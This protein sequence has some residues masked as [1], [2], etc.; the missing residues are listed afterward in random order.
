MPVL[1]SIAATP[2]HLRT[3]S[4]EPVSIQHALH[5][6]AD[7][8]SAELATLWGSLLDDVEDEIDVSTVTQAVDDDDTLAVLA[9]FA[10]AWQTAVERPAR[11]LLPVLLTQGVSQAAARIQDATR[12]ALGLT[13]LVAFQPGLAEVDQAVA[14]Y[15]GA[16]VYAIGTTS[17]RAGYVAWHVA[18]ELG[19]GTARYR[20]RLL[21]ALAGLTPAQVSTALRAEETLEAQQVPREVI[22]TEVDT[23]AHDGRQLRAQ[24]IAET[25]AMDTVNLGQQHLWEQ[26]AR[27]GQLDTDVFR[28]YWVLADEDACVRCAPVPAL[29]ADG[30]ALGGLFHTPIGDV[31]GPTLHPRCRCTLEGH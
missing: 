16:Q 11:R 28:Q 29:N 12:L 2:R 26:A 13:A 1:V 21:R 25:Q 19:H 18:R 27:A 20:A 7:T 5:Q 30:V 31:T 15:A 23:L 8:L 9:L 17:Q 4:A 24:Q 10:A 3:A 14:A 22:L 6:V